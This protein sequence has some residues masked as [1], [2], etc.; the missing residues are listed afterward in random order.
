MGS[1]QST[2]HAEPQC[3]PAQALAPALAP[4]QTLCA[5]TLVATKT[6]V[7]FA[8]SAPLECLFY[9]NDSLDGF[10]HYCKL[11]ESHPYLTRI[12][13]TWD[14]S[15]RSAFQLLPSLTEVFETD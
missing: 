8:S 5:K 1:E 10:E 6:L 3:T 12:R 13:Q 9:R 4:E 11:E 7:P 15:I 2:A 14:E